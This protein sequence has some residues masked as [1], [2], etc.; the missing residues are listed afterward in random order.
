MESVQD[1]W[2]CRGGQ[3]GARLTGV[4]QLP[5]V[6]GG[7]PDTERWKRG[8]A[9]AAVARARVLQRFRVQGVHGEAK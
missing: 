5:G 4:D 1:L 9:G 2:R 3:G 8:S 6:V 7:L